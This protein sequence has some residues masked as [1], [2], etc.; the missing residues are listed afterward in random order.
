MTRLRLRPILAAAVLLSGL[1]LATARADSCADPGGIQLQVLGSGGPIADDGRSSSAYLLWV[2][3]KARILID[4]GGGAFLRF[5]ESGASF[6]DVDFVA[7]SHFHTDHVADFVTLLKTA[8]LTGRDRPLGV[9]GPTGSGPFPSLDTFID[10]NLGQDGAYAYLG[11]FVAG[12]NDTRRLETVTVDAEKSQS[13]PVYSDPE[14]DIEISGIGVPHGIVPAIG[15]RVRIGEQ[16]F[17]F[18]SDQ[19]G[20][21]DAFIDFAKGVQ[22]LVMHMVVGNDA[23]SGIRALH[24]TP[25]RIGEIAAVADPGKLVLSHL[26]RWSLSDLDRNVASV[27]EHFDGEIVIADDLMCIAID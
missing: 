26:T 4:F 23:N 10:K 5:G 19:N 13:M 9:S 25:G 27:R 6:N 1:S 12:G 18:A 24:A 21:D 15:Y 2:D 3:G 22:V 11:G 16:T 7:I 20:G 8:A 14:N 17:V